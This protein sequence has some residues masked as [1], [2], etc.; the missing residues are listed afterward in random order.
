MQARTDWRAELSALMRQE[1]DRTLRDR[2]TI[3]G[4]WYLWAGIGPVVRILPSHEKPEG[5][6][7]V[8]PRRLSP[9]DNVDKA[10]AQYVPMLSRM[11]ILPT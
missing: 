5:L 8:D 3:G 11:P 6:E 4:E 9:W 7:L 10:I 1:W 2:A